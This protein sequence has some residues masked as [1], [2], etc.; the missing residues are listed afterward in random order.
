MFLRPRCPRPLWSEGFFGRRALLPGSCFPDVPNLGVLQVDAACSPFLSMN[1]QV[2]VIPWVG[3]GIC[4]GA[5]RGEALTFTMAL[6][7]LCAV[8]EMSTLEA[9]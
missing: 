8:I 2:Q 5:G 6:F 7:G 9:L 3:V 1:S 4:N